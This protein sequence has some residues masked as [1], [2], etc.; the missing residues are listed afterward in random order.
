MTAGARLWLRIVLPITTAP[1][2]LAALSPSVPTERVPLFLQPAV[3]AV[4]G[5]LL[6]VVLTR[7]PPSVGARS[8]SLGVLAARWGILGLLATNEELLWRRIAFGELLFGGAAAALAATTVGFALAHRGRPGPHL[9]S[10]GMFGGLYAATGGLTTSIVAHWVYNLNV[11]SAIA[12]PARRTR[13]A[14]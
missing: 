5:C 11:R 3:G 10:G 13:D 8:A 6:F 2:L 12:E 14:R 9:L 1:L 7:R 4:A